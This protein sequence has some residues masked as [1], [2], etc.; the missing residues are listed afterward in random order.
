[1]EAF[2]GRKSE[3]ASLE[4]EYRRPHSFVVMYGRRRVGKTTLIKEFMKGK[5]AL[6]FLATKEIESE[7]LKNFSGCLA[8]FTGQSYYENIKFPDWEN[9]VRA[10]CDYK[11]ETKK[12]LVIDE[13]QYL[14][15]VNKAF[16]SVFQR[17]WD[18]VLSQS[19][20]MVI[21]CGSLISM[22]L[23][24]VLAYKSPLYGRRTSQ[25]RLSPLRFSEMQEFFPEME[26]EE[27]VKLYSTTG[28]IPK[29]IELYFEENSIDRFVEEEIFS[30]QGFLFEEPTFLLEKE[31]KE[32]IS[33][34][35]IIKTISFGNHKLG[36]I[37]SSLEMSTSQ[38][39]PYL[40]TLIDLDIV[41][42]RLPVTEKNT[43][44][45]KMGLYYIKDHFIDFWFKFVS[46]YKSE[47]EIE[48]TAPAIKRYKENFVDSHESY[49]F[50]EISKE[51]IRMLCK[52]GYVDFPVLKIGKYW[53]NNTEI[54][55]CVTSDE[56]DRFILGECKFHDKPVDA[57]VYFNLQG[58]AEKLKEFRD[59]KI[60]YAV[61]SKSGFTKR[62]MD[63]AMENE[64]LMLINNGTL[65]S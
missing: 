5:E 58:K 4:K 12:I 65:I 31:V 6:Y 7:N 59:K 55:V 39:T 36:N 32:T 60:L 62:L 49:V 9:A 44:K 14:A 38:I 34:F 61:F 26:F 1:M 24:K 53:N 17:I 51:T 37:A 64:S 45:S 11:P 19:N 46:P 13:F 63:I 41:E 52:N 8:R 22:M 18:E 43:E 47:L 10:F 25:I 15:D 3:L 29:Y 42:K 28:G 23:K 27:L 16:V 20:V 21:I 48:N 2:I 57:D 35:S 33:Y 54:D 30:K 40:K 56:E 50:E